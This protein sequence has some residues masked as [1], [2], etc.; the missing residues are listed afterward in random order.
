[1]ENGVYRLSNCSP[2]VLRVY[3]SILDAASNHGSESVC[4][5][6]TDMSDVVVQCLLCH[7]RKLRRV[8]PRLP[9]RRDDQLSALLEHDAVVRCPPRCPSSHPSK[10]PLGSAMMTSGRWTGCAMEPDCGSSSVLE[11]MP[12]CAPLIVERVVNASKQALPPRESHAKR[13]FGGHL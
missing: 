13:R 4:L 12:G 6:V 11:E 7:L 1:M 10:S 3:N 5:H 9:L 8:M 2:C